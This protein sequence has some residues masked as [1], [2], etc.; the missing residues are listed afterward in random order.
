M[1]DGPQGPFQ[2]ALEGALPPLGAGAFLFLSEL[3]PPK[4]GRAPQDSDA[5]AL[6]SAW[7]AQ[8]VLR[9]CDLPGAERAVVLS[10]REGRAARWSLPLPDW[11]PEAAEAKLRA[12]CGD[13]LAGDPGPLPLEA[14]LAGT[15]DL[16]AWI[17]K[18]LE[19][20]EPRFSSLWGPIPATALPPPAI[21]WA[22]RAERRLGDFLVACK[23]AG[24]P[25]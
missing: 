19:E 13:L 11:T 9:A 5:R 18:A 7:V 10:V 15:E 21:D 17:G 24:D 1:F 22:D 6:L 16:E 25:A 3:E 8:A 14:L 2:V 4:P 20:P 23:Q 12:W